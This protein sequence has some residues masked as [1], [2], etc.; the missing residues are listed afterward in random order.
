MTKSNATVET[1]ETRTLMASNPLVITHGG[2]YT[3]TWESD[4]ANV[5]AVTVKTT[6]AVI[7]ENSV[8][9]GRGDLIVAG[10]DHTNIT[11]RNTTGYGLNPNVYGKAPG[12]FFEAE[13]F[14]NVVLD[15]NDLENTAGIYLLTYGGDFSGNESVRVA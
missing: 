7:I 2:T 8:V 4:D 6:E 1:L 11:V 3:G 10:I 14:D 13:V 15:N 12:R 9:K 5:P